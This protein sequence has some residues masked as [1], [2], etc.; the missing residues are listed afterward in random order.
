MMGVMPGPSGPPPGQTGGY[1]GNTGYQ[2]RFGYAM[3][4][5][6]PTPALGGPNFGYPVV[7]TATKFVPTPRTEEKLDGEEGDAKRPRKSQM[8]RTVDYRF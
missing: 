3:K 6:L 8:R 1:S 5:R 7:P 2:P 4:P